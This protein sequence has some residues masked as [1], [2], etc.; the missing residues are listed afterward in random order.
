M[1][2]TIDLMEAIMEGWLREKGTDKILL[3]LETLIEYAKG[4]GS[5][6][7]EEICRHKH[8]PEIYQLLATSQDKIGWRHFMKGMI[9]KEIGTAS[10]STL[11][12]DKW[13]IGLITRQ[14]I[15]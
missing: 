3:E 15:T 12:L 10:G 5:V 13:T 8:K 1:H 11:S 7:M 4:R 2:M 9:S 14:G 6:T